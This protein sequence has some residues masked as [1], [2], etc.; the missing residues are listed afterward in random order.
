MESKNR[1]NEKSQ[2]KRRGQ[3]CRRTK[4]KKNKIN[5]KNNALD[6]IVK[7]SAGRCASCLFIKKRKD[8]AEIKYN[9]QLVVNE[10]K[11]E[12]IKVKECWDKH[13]EK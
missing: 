9:E 13:V 11:E 4:I 2:E 12:L 1:S 8:M 5:S 3:S 10:D 6:I 7:R